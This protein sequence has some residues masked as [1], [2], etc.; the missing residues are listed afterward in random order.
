MR[1]LVI[2][3]SPAKAKTIEK[4]LGSEFAVRSSI[5]HIRSIAKK[6]KTGAPPIDTANDFTTTYEIDSDKKKTI[7]ELK[8]MVKQV[9]KQN[10]WLATDEDREGE[11]IAWHLCEVLGLDAATTK[12]IVFHEITKTAITDA[13]KKPRTI[14]MSLVEAQQ[15]R[16]ILDRLVGFELSPV[17]WRKVPGGKSAGRVQSPAVRLLVEREREITAFEST[18]TFRVSALF[19]H[20]NQEFKAELSERFDDEDA[21]RSFLESIQN[22]TFAVGD[23]TKKPGTRNPS[24]PFTTSTLQQE[25]N[26]KL[27][28]GSKATMA[29][30][31]KL[32]QD[33][34][35]TYMRTDSTNLSGQAI[36]SATEYIKRLYGPEYSQVRK[37]K[38]KNASAQEAHEAIRPTDISRETASNNEY[39]QKLYDL[40]RRR[41]LASQMTAATLE[42]TTVTIT[43]ANATQTFTAKGQAI[44]FD[45][46]L[47]VYG[48]NKDELLPQLQRGDTLRVGTISA[49]QQFAKPP[50]RY[51][52][53]SLVKKLEELGIGRPS[54]YATIV[55]TIQTRGYVEKGENEG[56]ER[57]VIVLE[58]L[59]NDVERSVVQEKTGA[60]RGK[61][62]PTPSGELIADFLGDHF[63]QI[64]D[65]DFTAN[66]EEE[67]DA[68]A[69]DTMARNAML[70]NFYTPFHELIA[71]SGDIDRS[72]VGQNR[73][74]GTD[75]KSGKPIFA[76]F[77]RF[78]PMLQLGSQDAD[79]KPQF[80][81]LPKG[82]RIE[83]VSLDEALH[84]FKLPRTVG[85][86][87]DGQDIKANIG[88][89]GPYIQV[90][91]LFV[92]IKPEDPHDITLEKAREL[93]QEKLQK[94]AEKHIADFGD[95]VKVL[96]GRFGPYVTNGTK[97]AKIPKD[98]DP[99]SLSHDDAKELLDKAPAKKRG[100]AK[101]RK[102]K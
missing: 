90:G 63:A 59:D 3:E 96:N 99:K 4:Y 60:T 35:I 70:R 17:V 77:G 31:Q 71:N 22:A 10:V 46:F 55:D 43:I 20:D 21:A 34:K 5:G 23:V 30:A 85:Q 27:G 69:A 11:A 86:T 48:A 68:I 78:G 28:F 64:V 53:G 91:K 97:N 72:S 93:Y 82:A 7:A 39:D 26:A 76:R 81:P 29:A 25:A 38:T 44:T 79:E 1:N 41:T 24:A 57:D 36:A 67:F 37:F 9:G 98:T 88:R 95:G 2:V 8:K 84:A 92:S 62:V 32:Y 45:G 89:F 40:I 52:E 73:E 51:S 75:P 42:N 18:S 13:I 14:D 12:R 56:N 61:L 101:T 54:T 19:H 66:V 16:Q 94:E 58:L 33:G 80:A 15:A 47:R 83:T 74:V 102:R 87:E 65:Y 49:R 100:G 6:T 50:A